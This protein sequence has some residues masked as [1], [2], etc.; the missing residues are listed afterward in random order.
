MLQQVDDLETLIDKHI[1]SF[2]L[3]CTKEKFSIVL[4]WS[5]PSQRLMKVVLTTS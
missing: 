5:V 4:H 3:R 1:K 2:F